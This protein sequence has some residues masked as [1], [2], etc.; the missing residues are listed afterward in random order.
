MATN[1][2]IIIKLRPEDKGNIVSYDKNKLP[3][4]VKQEEWIERDLHTGKVYL[5]FRGKEKSRPIYIANHEYIG[6]FCNWDG[7]YIGEWLDKQFETHEEVLNL[8]VG[9]SCST[10]WDG[11]VR[12]YANKKGE[13][14]KYLLP[15]QGD[16][17]EDVYSKITSQYLHVY[18]NGWKHYKYDGDALTS[19]G[20]TVAGILELKKQEYYG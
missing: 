19:D 11:Y 14:F 1:S 6:I 10:V 13:L 3:K 9:G 2:A 18:D 5:D 8:I 12:R 16:K 20:R 17:L 4:G 15:V 7:K